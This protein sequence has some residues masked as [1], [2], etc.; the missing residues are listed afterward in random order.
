[1]NETL[2]Q[3][4]KRFTCDRCEYS[5]DRKGNFER[6]IKMVHDQIK[7]F[8][9]DRDG[10]KKAF[11][12]KGHLNTHIKMVHDQIKDFVCDRD[13]CEMA[14]STNGS[15][16]AHIK[17]VHDKIKDFVCDIDGCKKAFCRNG[18]LQAHIKGVHDKIK[19]FVCDRDNCKMA[20][21]SNVNLQK[22]IKMVH[23]KIK[24]F[25]CDRNGCKKAFCTNSDLQT[26]IKG[27]HDKIKDFLCDIDGCKK[28]FCTNSKLKRHLANIHDIE[29]KW[30]YCPEDNCDYKSKS[31]DNFKRHQ[32]TCMGNGGVGS[33]GEKYVKQCLSDLGFLLTED[34]VYDQT[35]QP[36]S[37][38]TNK[39]LRFDF[40][41]L[42]HNI[43]IE[44][45]GIQHFEPQR[46][47]GISQEQA[48]ENFKEL[49]ENDKLKN[50]FCKENNFKMIRIPY[51][52]FP[53]TLS[54]LSTE[55]L[56]IVN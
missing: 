4:R 49:Q 37:Q 9:C 11:S 40:R 18:D 46:F 20:F 51:T 47:G 12:T 48:E 5:S 15:L 29:V 34:Y 42:N 27:V 38:Y 31:K 21:T 36:L 41:F 56:D 6:H 55:L 50:D 24:D 39:N 35:F 52:E 17:G 30:F 22:H 28:A 7:D 10:C 25:V 3:E 54:I 13:G 43:I 19:D 32:Q 2:N 1:M 53:N 26:H 23:D 33:N 44:Y 45:D 8:V 14:F 16:Q